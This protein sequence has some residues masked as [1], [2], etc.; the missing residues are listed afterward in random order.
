MRRYAMAAFL[1]TAISSQADAQV[2][3]GRPETGTYSAR[4][5]VVDGVRYYPYDTGDYALGGFAGLARFRG[6]FVILSPDGAPFGSESVGDGDANYGPRHR[7]S[8]TLRIGSF[9]R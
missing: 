9:H 7:R 4:P 8:C 5:I 3:G 2:V 6:Y 1:I